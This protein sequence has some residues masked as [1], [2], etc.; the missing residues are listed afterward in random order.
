[1][2]ALGTFQFSH[3]R[4]F[5][6]HRERCLR[7][8]PG[9]LKEQKI[10]SYR[11]CSKLHYTKELLLSVPN[12]YIINSMLMRFLENLVFVASGFLHSHPEVSNN[13]TVSTS[14]A[15]SIH[16]KVLDITRLFLRCFHHKSVSL[17][18]S[19]GFLNVTSSRGL[20]KP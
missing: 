16:L 19:I 9:F 4:T 15:I 12:C 3:I 8:V 14:N 17:F 13:L 5:I 18:Q 6:V 7:W 10:H 11:P 2:Q 1:M 20:E